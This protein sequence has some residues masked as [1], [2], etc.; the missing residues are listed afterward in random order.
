LCHIGCSTVLSFA[1]RIIVNII[2][3][4]YTFFHSSE[5]VLYTEEEKMH[6]KRMNFGCSIICFILIF[7]VFIFPVFPC[8][9][10]EKHVVVIPLNSQA[11]GEKQIYLPAPMFRPVLGLTAW[12]F[13]ADG[14]IINPNSAG[15]WIAPIVLPVGT[16]ITSLELV[17]KNSDVVSTGGFSSVA[18]HVLNEETAA[19]LTVYTQSS[20]ITSPGVHKVKTTFDFVV[21][22]TLHPL[23]SVYFSHPDRWL[24]GVKVTYRE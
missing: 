23:A 1:G 4:L 17:W 2:S 7:T 5:N 24:L 13:E 6:H 11:H 10:A 9:A 16:T 18:L 19:S 14:G 12:Q 8:F 15:Y 21:S 3:N 20:S 22:D